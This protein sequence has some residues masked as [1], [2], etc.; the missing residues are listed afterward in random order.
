V[1]FAA[2][3]ILCVSLLSSMRRRQRGMRRAVRGRRA[4]GVGVRGARIQNID[5]YATT[6]DVHAARATRR[7]AE[8]KRQ[9]F[10]ALAFCRAR[11]RHHTPL[12]RHFD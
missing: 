11:L 5:I 8:Q 9:T 7:G 2:R 3:H 1:R 10:S 4:G 6:D 12:P